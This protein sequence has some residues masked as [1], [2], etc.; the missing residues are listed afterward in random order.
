M[1]FGYVGILMLLSLYALG[2]AK[3]RSEAITCANSMKQ[4]VLA[5]ATWAIDNEGEYPFNVSMSQG[6]SMELCSPGANGFD[7]NSAAHLLIIS[8]E[9][10]TTHILVCPADSSKRWA[11][12]WRSLQ[13]SNVSY[14][15]HVGTNVDERYPDEVLAVCPI[16]GHVVLCNGSVQFGPR[17][18]SLTNGG[19]CKSETE[20][21][22][23]SLLYTPH[24]P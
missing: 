16:Q 6:G 13:S 2:R 24:Q 22:P 12:D 14:Q 15:I 11:L 7:N 18:R 5:F 20:P 1:A 3:E 23:A 17:F 4:V 21:I 8:N 19:A 10:Q 9:L